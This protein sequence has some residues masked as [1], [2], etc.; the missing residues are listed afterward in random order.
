M[1]VSRD[2][3]KK[4]HNTHLGHLSISK[5]L[6]SDVDG[7]LSQGIEPAKVLDMIKDD[8]STIDS[9][10]LV[11]QKDIHNKKKSIQYSK[12]HKLVD[13][14]I[15]IVE[16]LAEFTALHFYNDTNNCFLISFTG[17]SASG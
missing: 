5:E 8:I 12:A 17:T 1:N 11:S 2:L 4:S 6:R 3:M 16:A 9:D 15:N 10:N 7:K 13:I 14:W